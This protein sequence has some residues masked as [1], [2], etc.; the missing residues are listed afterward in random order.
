MKFKW[1]PIILWRHRV[2]DEFFRSQF[3]YTYILHHTVLYYTISP[4]S[5]RSLLFFRLYGFNSIEM[6]EK[7]MRQQLSE[8]QC[9]HLVVALSSSFFFFFFTLFVATLSHEL[10]ANPVH[11]YHIGNDVSV[12]CKHKGMNEQN[13]K[14]MNS[15]TLIDAIC[16]QWSCHHVYYIS[17]RRNRNAVLGPIYL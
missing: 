10:C 6:L 8:M 3:K 11:T 2:C 1:F 5:G 9:P 12:H 13:E 7:F 16:S 17:H 14:I 4:Y 15:T